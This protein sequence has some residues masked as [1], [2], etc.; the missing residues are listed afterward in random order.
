MI[1]ALIVSILVVIHLSR[2]VFRLTSKGRTQIF[3][4]IQAQYLQVNFLV[5]FKIYVKKI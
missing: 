4:L 1:C 5:L 2:G 3:S